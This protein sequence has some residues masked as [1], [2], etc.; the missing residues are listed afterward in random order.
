MFLFLTALADKIFFSYFMLEKLNQCPF[1][2]LTLTLFKK[3]ETGITLVSDL[4]WVIYNASNP[5]AF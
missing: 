3:L 5:G 4:S 2:Q 1:W